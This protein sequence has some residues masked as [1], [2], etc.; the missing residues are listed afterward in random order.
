MVLVVPP[1]SDLGWRVAFDLRYARRSDRASTA[2]TVMG[3]GPV[4][5][6]PPG[7]LTNLEWYAADTEAHEKFCSRLAEHRTLVLYDRHG[8]GLS[9]RNRTDFTFE[10]DMKD[11]EAVFEAV[12]WTM[13]W[14]V[15][16]S[17]RVSLTETEVNFRTIT[18]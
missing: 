4:L 5:V 8:C 3:S 12:P 16:T 18:P 6:V 11:L 17:M 13:Y 7:G 2:Y 9:D 10:D 1:D 14:A 15:T